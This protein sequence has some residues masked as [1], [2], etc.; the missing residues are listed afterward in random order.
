MAPLAARSQLMGLETDERMDIL[1]SRSAIFDATR[2]DTA[3]MRVQLMCAA[4]CDS[5][6]D[7][8]M[9]LK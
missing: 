1:A 4:L 3:L 8:I 9:N 7:G 5:K 2:A 6:C